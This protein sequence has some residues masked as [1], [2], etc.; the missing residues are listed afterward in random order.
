MQVRLEDLIESCEGMCRKVATDV[1]ANCFLSPADVD[2]LTQTARMAVVEAAGK[3]E[4][5]EGAKFSTFAYVVIKSRVRTAASRIRRHYSLAVA[6]EDEVWD[7]EP[8]ARECTEDDVQRREVFAAIERM[9][10]P[11]YRELLRMFVMDRKRFTEIGVALGLQGKNLR[12]M[13]NA[14]MHK[15]VAQLKEMMAG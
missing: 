4:E 1:V 5:R 8:A 10:N 13:I 7:N 12:A 15:A 14:R 2:D 9:P 3:F 11:E 6:G